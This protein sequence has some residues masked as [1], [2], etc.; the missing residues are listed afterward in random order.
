MKNIKIVKKTLT[1]I[2]LYIVIMAFFFQIQNFT[3]KPTYDIIATQI[4]I[5][6]YEGESKGRCYMNYLIYFVT[7]IVLIISYLITR[8]LEKKACT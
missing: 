4:G 7:P 6:H 1:V 8:Q 5:S 3:L 2:G